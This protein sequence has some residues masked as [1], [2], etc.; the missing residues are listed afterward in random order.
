MPGSSEEE[1]DSRTA[2]VGLQRTRVQNQDSHPNKRQ[3]R[4]RGNSANSDVRDF[5]PQGGTFSAKPLEVD[6]DDTSSSG[7]DSDS[8]SN[9]SDANPNPYAGTTSQAVN[10]NQGNKRAIRT[11]LGGRGKANNNKKPEPQPQPEPEKESD[12]QFDAVNGAY[13]R[14]RSESV[15]TGNGDNDKK[16][17]GQDLEEGEV[18]ED[19]PAL[20][21]SGD[22]DDSESL[23]SEADDSILLNLGQKEN[24]HAATYE[25]DDYDPEMQPFVGVVISNGTP[26]KQG[27]QNGT[28]TD[29]SKEETI[30]IFTQRYPSPP[31]VMT[32]LVQE[33]K[34]FQIR[35]MYW[36]ESKDPQIPISCTECMQEGH[37]AQVC[38]SKECTH[39]SAWD[40][41][42]S[43]FCPTWR[44]CQRCRER[45]HDE[46]Q[47]SSLLK[48]SASEVPCDLCGSQDHLELDCDYM[49]KLP[50]RDPSSGPVLVSISCSRCTSNNHLAGDCP[51]LPR[52]L[53]SSSW[54]LKG[55]D[56]NMVTN[57]NSVIP[58]RSRPGPVARGRGGMKIRG[59]AERSPTP[60]SDEDDGIFTRP[61][62]RP[63]PPGRGGGR[64][65]IRI[66]GGIGRGKNLGPGGYRD[67]ND[68]FGDRSRQRS[69][70]P[71]G[72]PGP[73]PGRGRGARDNWNVR[74][75][76]PPR[77]GRPP[78]PP[79]RGGRGRG[80]GGGGGK[81]GGGGGDAYRP[82][83][84][85][86]KKNWDRYRF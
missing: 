5:V 24:G 30:R 53:N 3:R 11:T 20:D 40:K 42:D 1:N 75:R 37:I 38:P 83:P 70:S 82:M 50:L 45:G 68:S 47:C 69:L 72:R 36:S 74:S 29:A 12:A 63:P 33:D 59:R 26:G 78:P 39:C 25:N 71:I 65:N 86:A 62:Q 31:A 41:H 48:G 28:A 17:E 32:D 43:N 9:W 7:S 73:G 58:G 14:S 22:S 35:F 76:S 23:D 61:N 66:G 67:R 57:I 19:A 56:P 51:S 49:W 85:A 13:W 54:T 6:Q 79:S 21:T 2:S 10:W 44:R 16:D 64:G 34:D 4:T 27:K 84:S 15:S 52:P 77:R 80:G 55:I 81:R 60:D 46:A 8:G 18:N